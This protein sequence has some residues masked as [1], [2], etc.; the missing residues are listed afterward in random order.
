MVISKVQQ[1][2]QVDRCIQVAIHHKSA[3]FTTVHTLCQADLLFMATLGTALAGWKETI[4]HAHFTTVPRTLV[5]QLPAEFM[6]AHI[7]DRL[8]Q[9]AILHHPAH[10][11]V[12]QHDR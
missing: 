5:L 9:M 1:L 8:C 2:F 3:C 10:I 7:R 12:L 4:R 6:H 11:Q